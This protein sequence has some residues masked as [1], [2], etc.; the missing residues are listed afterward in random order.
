M[1]TYKN[2]IDLLKNILKNF[3][4]N[5]FDDIIKNILSKIFDGYYMNRNDKIYCLDN[6]YKK[7]DLSRYN[8][9]KKR[10]GVVKNEKFIFRFNRYSKKSYVIKLLKEDFHVILEE[11]ETYQLV[12][13]NIL[14]VDNIKDYEKHIY[15]IYK[16]KFLSYLDRKEDDYKKVDVKEDACKIDF[17]NIFGEK[18]CFYP[19]WLNTTINDNYCSNHNKDMI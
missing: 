3:D 1:N 14:K 19:P 13:D 7:Y 5:E 9:I 4:N 15:N 18:I 17:N 6:L 2:Y 10:Y 8:F 12:A 16:D 11:S